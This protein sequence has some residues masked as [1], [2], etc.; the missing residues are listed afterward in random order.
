MTDE[1]HRQ[2]GKLLGFP[3]CCIEA[4]IADPLPGQGIRRGYIHLGS[5]SLEEARCLNA[6]I[7]AILGRKW[8]TDGEIR[9]VPCSSCRARHMDPEAQHEGIWFSHYHEPAVELAPAPII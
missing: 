2:L 5:R 6:Q 4:W 3:E 8:R 1:Q 7:S 9:Y